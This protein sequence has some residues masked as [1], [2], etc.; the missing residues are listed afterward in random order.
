MKK[1]MKNLGLVLLIMGVLFGIKP[2]QACIMDDYTPQITYNQNAKCMTIV[3]STDLGIVDM[4]DTNEVLNLLEAMGRNDIKT[5]INL[6]ESIANDK[7]SDAAD[8]ILV[9]NYSYY[10]LSSQV[11]DTLIR[12]LKNESF[13]TG[14]YNIVQFFG[15]KY[16]N[17]FLN[18]NWLDFLDYSN[19]LDYSHI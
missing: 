19:S 8:K 1:I 7:A 11:Y 14:N 10:E 6:N 9:I 13:I 17:S 3:D 5:V 4:M 16:Q 12:D 15:S 2:A 18:T